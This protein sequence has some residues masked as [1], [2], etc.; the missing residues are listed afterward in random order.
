M[1]K[2]KALT[3]SI[4]STTIALGFSSV[5]VA[6]QLCKQVN[7]YVLN[8]F[9]DRNNPV[10]IKVFKLNYYDAEDRKWRVSKVG[11]PGIVTPD[12]GN[13]VPQPVMPNTL[14]YVGNE[15]ILGMQYQFRFQ[16]SNGWSKPLWS[17]VTRFTDS[18]PCVKGKQY[19]L[20]IDSG[21]EERE[22]EP[23]DP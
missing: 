5:A 15:E 7:A 1:S 23:L 8:H 4:L 13:H 12:I 16:E 11:I 3:L 17:N 10:T 9:Q 21:T 22:T 18:G 20:T 19:E 6:D 2:I 14:E